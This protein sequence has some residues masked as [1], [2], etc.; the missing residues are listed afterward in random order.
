MSVRAAVAA[1]LSLAVLTGCGGSGDEGAEA[2]SVTGPSGTAAAFPVTIEHTFGSTTIEEQPERVVTLGWSAQDIV[3]ALD[4]TPV[5]MPAATYGA[6]EDGVLPWLQDHYDPTETELLDMADGPPLEAIAALRPDVILA[7]YA[8][9]EAS[10]YEQLS[11]IAPTVAYPGQPWA[12]PWREQTRIVGKALGVS[13]E[14]EQLVEDVDQLLA[15][16][17]AEHPEF[18][19]LTFAY[20][21]MGSA[22]MYVYLPNDPRVQLVESLGMEVAPSVAELAAGTGDDQF[23]AEVSLERA[24]EIASDVLVGFADDLSVPEI[25][26]SPIYS[27]LPALQDDAAVLIDDESF[28]AAVSS[29]SVLSIPWVLDRL[30]GRLATAAENAAA[31]Q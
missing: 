3:Y 14:A 24:P 16:N 7:P 25:T 20:T 21:S 6:D 12:T 1:A 15:A 13:E 8:G 31:P 30:V 11:G 10:V 23:Y 28:G 27:R 22:L 18:E 19:G 2:A 9:F 4:V 17:A 29:V 5:G 26:A